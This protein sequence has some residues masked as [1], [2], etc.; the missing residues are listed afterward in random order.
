M[1]WVNHHEEYLAVQE[2]TVLPES[3]IRSCAGYSIFV[4]TNPRIMPINGFPQ[5]SINAASRAL[6]EK[7][8]TAFPTEQLL[9]QRQTIR[10]V[11]ITQITYQYKKNTRYFC[12]YGLEKKVYFPDYPMT[13]YSGYPDDPDDLDLSQCCAIS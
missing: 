4:D 9:Q 5:E 13:C 2:A 3:E 8:K 7:H 1:S 10:V 12:I 6:I 11:P